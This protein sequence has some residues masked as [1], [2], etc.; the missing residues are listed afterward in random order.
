MSSLYS[1]KQPPQERL[2][3]WYPYY[4]GYTAIFARSVLDEYLTS[5]ASIVDPWNGSGTTTAVAT[6][7]GIKSVG[8]DV[9]PALTIV[10]RA[11]LTPRSVADSLPPIAAEI[12]RLAGHQQLTD[13]ESEPLSTWLLAPSVRDIRRLQHAIHVVTS[14]D[15]ALESELAQ[16]VASA[17]TRLPLITAFF[18]AALFASCRDLLRRFRRSNPT[19]LVTP[20]SPRRRLRPGTTTIE[21]AFLERVRYLCARLSVDRTDAGELAEIRT[22]PAERLL[23]RRPAFDACLTSP[24]YATR[25]DYIRGSVPELSVL[26][27][28]ANAIAA[29]RRESTG[30]P[31]IRGVTV[32]ENDLPDEASALVERVAKHDSHGSANYYA[33]WLRNYLSRLHGTL[34]GIASSVSPSGRIALVVQDSYYKTIHIDLQTLVELSLVASGR[35]LLRQH[36]FEVNHSMS[37]MN[38]RARQH[39]PKRTHRESLLVFE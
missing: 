27:L 33:P 34:C 17:P 18:Y 10:A 2:K 31:V 29:L 21:T 4:A 36:D 7:R 20:G 37:Y 19:W 16:G 12:V 14:A 24:P 23:S 38:T 3:D 13:R 25:I 26:G 39:L 5:A 35:R 30:T 6:S 11:R 9:N 28:A 32:P 1:P 15:P 8:T 22:E